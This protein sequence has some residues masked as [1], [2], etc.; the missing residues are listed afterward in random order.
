VRAKPAPTL[1]REAL[2][3]LGVAADEAIAFEDSPNGARAAHAAGIF[4]VGI[5][6]AVTAELDLHADADLIVD[7]LAVLPPLELLARFEQAA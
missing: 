1:Y 3:L 7:S 4:V 2:E 5:P 6:N